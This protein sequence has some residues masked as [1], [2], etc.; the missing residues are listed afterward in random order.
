VHRLLELYTHTIPAFGHCRHVQELLF[1]TSHQS[2]KRGISR[3]NQ[4]DP[5]IHSVTATIANDW[6][7]RLSIAVD[8]CGDPDSW[9]IEDCKRIR[10]LITGRDISGAT[11][12]HE[13]RSAF[14]EPVL[15]QLRKVRRKLKSNAQQV[16][17]WKLHYEPA[18]YAHL[19][20]SWRKLSSANVKAFDE[21]VECV[22]SSTELRSFQP[23]SLRV[24]CY[25]SLGCTR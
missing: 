1:E 10:R 8:R 25:A 24:A 9:T 5:H 19:N 3:S 13:I 22:K 11:D 16:V 14:C 20:E 6:E 21:A 18:K 23:K 15:S 7:C 12:M 4:R 2:F 17:V